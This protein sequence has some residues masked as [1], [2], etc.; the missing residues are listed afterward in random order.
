MF[1]ARQGQDSLFYSGQAG[2]MWGLPNIIYN[3]DFSPELK[4][5]GVKVATNFHA[6]SRLITFGAV[7]LSSTRLRCVVRR[8]KFI[9]S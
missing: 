9:T 6:V 4:L 2:G 5:W 3:G 8:F 7:L 1:V